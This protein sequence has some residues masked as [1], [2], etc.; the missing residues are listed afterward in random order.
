MTAPQEALCHNRENEGKA[1][2]PVSGS[3]KREALF[4]R[5]SMEQNKAIA[6]RDHKTEGQQVTQV[7]MKKS[8][9]I[10]KMKR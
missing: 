5:R 3:S 6:R 8:T 1:I 9:F 10:K 4:C 2:K 7:R